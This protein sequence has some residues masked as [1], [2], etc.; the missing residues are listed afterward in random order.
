M[1][2]TEAHPMT[3]LVYEIEDTFEGY[4]KPVIIDVTYS[5]GND[6]EFE[7]AYAAVSEESNPDLSEELFEE[8]NDIVEK[9]REQDYIAE[10]EKFYATTNIKFIAE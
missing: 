9:S 7:F 1:K 3:G 2:L 10:L 6:D 4:D 8:F 5:G